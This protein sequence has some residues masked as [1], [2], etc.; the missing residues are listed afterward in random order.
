MIHDKRFYGL[1]RVNSYITLLMFHRNFPFRNSSQA[2]KN[3][4]KFNFTDCEGRHIDVNYLVVMTFLF[5]LF[6]HGWEWGLLLAA[7]SKAASTAFSATKA[8]P[9]SQPAGN[10]SGFTL[11]MRRYKFAHSAKD[12]ITFVCLNLYFKLKDHLELNIG[13]HWRI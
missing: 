1:R 9:P 8:P 13:A 3:C 10:Q 11:N 2:A 5:V 6:S 7:T 4:Q 12:P